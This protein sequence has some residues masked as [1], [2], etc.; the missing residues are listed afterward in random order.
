M[1][2]K[3][4][5]LPELMQEKIMAQSNYTGTIINSRPVILGSITSR[6]IKSKFVFSNKVFA[7]NL[8]YFSK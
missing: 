7:E 6:M 4:R 3:L 5:S 1:A 8:E 2:A